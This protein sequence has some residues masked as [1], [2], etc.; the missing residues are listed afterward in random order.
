MYLLYM[1]EKGL[2]CYL[3]VKQNHV[4]NCIYPEQ[5]IA[6][7]RHGG[8]PPRSVGAQDA[9]RPVLA[10]DSLLWFDAQN[11]NVFCSA[12]AIVRFLYANKLSNVFSLATSAVQASALIAFALSTTKMDKLSTASMESI[13]VCASA[14]LLPLMH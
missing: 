2:F 10:S 6:T 3:Q 1:S 8:L 5:I 7:P 11:A 13:K 9:Q 12:A 14:K 4:M